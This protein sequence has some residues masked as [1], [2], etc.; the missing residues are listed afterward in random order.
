MENFD[1]KTDLYTSRLL[2]LKSKKYVDPYE[3]RQLIKRIQED[4][5][6]Q[7]KDRILQCMIESLNNN[8]SLDEAIIK[9]NLTT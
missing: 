9:I 3:A 5:I 4:A 1:L 6:K 2:E 7:I 8:L